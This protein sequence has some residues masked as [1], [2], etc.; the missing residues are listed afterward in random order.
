MKRAI[1]VIPVLLLIGCTNATSKNGSESVSPSPV[2]SATASP[3]ISV[4]SSSPASA[5]PTSGPNA[6]LKNAVQAYSDAFLT[7]DIAAYDMLTERCRQRHSRSEF[8]SILALAKAR[9]GSK[10]PIRTYDAQI[11]GD[12]ARVTYTYDVAEINQTAE[13]W[14]REAGQWK[15][16]DC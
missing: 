12:L 13:P 2:Q 9:Y 8:A 10:L 6:E 15:E 4:A 16:D 3:A 7:G 1:L 14:A 5:S 11:S